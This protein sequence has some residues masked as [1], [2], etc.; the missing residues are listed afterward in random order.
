[1][2]PELSIFVLLVVVF[3]GWFALGTHTNVRKGHRFLEWLQDGLPLLGEKTTLNWLGS[4]V[5]QLKIE[6]AREPFRHAEVLVVLEPRD[7]P[8]IWLFSRLQGRCDLLIVRTQLRTPPKVQVEVLA[9]K[10]WSA[11]SVAQEVTQLNWRLQSAVADE[12]FQVYSPTPADAGELI[13]EAGRCDLPLVRIG[14]RKSNNGF[15]IQ[16]RLPRQPNLTSHAVFET[17]RRVAHQL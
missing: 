1:M 4:S 11:R 5:V 17:V 9:G 10:A 7:V 2:S 14:V 15:E 8:L 13:T 6:K 12:P 3:V 16:W